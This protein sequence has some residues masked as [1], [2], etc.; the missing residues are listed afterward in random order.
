MN[1]TSL[2]IETKSPKSQHAQIFRLPN[3][4]IFVKCRAWPPG[5]LLCLYK[6]CRYLWRCRQFHK[7]ASE[8]RLGIREGGGEEKSCEVSRLITLTRMLSTLYQQAFNTLQQYKSITDHSHNPHPHIFFSSYSC[9]YT[10]YKA[11]YIN[12]KT[13][14]YKQTL[15]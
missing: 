15:L 2:L 10:I 8:G 11:Y 3:N 5:L 13:P 4:N 7:N 6:R 14:S 12:L 9:S 1:T